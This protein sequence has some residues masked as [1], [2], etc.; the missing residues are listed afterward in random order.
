[1]CWEEEEGGGRRAARVSCNSELSACKASAPVGCCGCCWKEEEE[2]EETAPVL[3]WGV[4]KE[5]LWLLF[6]GRREGGVREGSFGWWHKHKHRHTDT[7]THTHTHTSSQHPPSNP[8]TTPLLRGEAS[9]V[10][11]GDDPLPPPAPPPPLPLLV[12]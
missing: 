2:E 10:F 11:C 3:C 5:C 6:G 9:R 4:E 12:L 1:M 8:A 7:H